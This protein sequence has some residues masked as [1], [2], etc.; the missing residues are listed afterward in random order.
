MS[1]DNTTRLTL[2]TVVRLLDDVTGQP[3]EASWRAKVER[4]GPNDQAALRILVMS[5]EM[6]TAD[7]QAAHEA[8]STR[9][10]GTGTPTAAVTAGNFAIVKKPSLSHSEKRAIE[11][12]LINYSQQMGQF[13]SQT[14]QLNDALARREFAGWASAASIIDAWTSSIRQLSADL[15]TILGKAR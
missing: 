12:A 6:K 13:S 7:V 2:Q 4:T 5:I 14:A 10:L 9:L 3:G 1:L 8:V 15:Q 11:S